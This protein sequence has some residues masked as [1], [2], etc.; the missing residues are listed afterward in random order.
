MKVI[1]LKAK[2]VKD[3]RKEPTVEIK[4][5][6]N[7][8]EFS[9]SA[10][11]GKSRGE[12]EAQ[13]WK[14]S[15]KGDIKAVNEYFIEDININSFDD[16][17]LIENAFNDRVGG[18]TMIALEYV[19]LKALAKQKNLEVWQLIN[20]KAEKM[21]LPIGNIIGGGKHSKKG[22]SSIQEFHIIPDSLNF[23]R[24]VEIMRRAH[25][26]A[27]EILKNLNKDFRKE[28]N[29]ENAWQTSL[30]DESIIEI[31]QDLR[32]NM[33]DEFDSKIHIGIDVAASEFYKNGKYSYKRKQINRNEQ[34]E[35]MKKLSKIFYYIEDPL[36]Q[37]DFQGF[38]EVN[39]NSKSIITGDDLTATNPDRLFKSIKT[40]SIKGII[41]KPN[42]VG[43]LLKVKEVISICKQNN[44]KTIFSHRSG[45]TSEDIIS[46]LAF[47]FEADFVKFG[48]LGK[49]RDEK[50]NRLVEIEE[51]L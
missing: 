15:L 45:E 9:A 2:E 40:R 38:S 24:N 32:D 7:L 29:D 27:G 13:V 1:S 33:K 31:M 20:P 5:A 28:K 51:S 14:K 44:I 47:G 48:T 50:L 11:N 42:Q 43:S 18:N 4:L 21:P 19:F 39:K 37:N 6:T 8:G 23:A 26:N 17:V 35:Y 10:P 25:E 34:I 49:G 36:E 41:V 30:D 12:F 22:N 46:D 16:L 3:T